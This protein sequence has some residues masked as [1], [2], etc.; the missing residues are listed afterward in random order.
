MLSLS[1]LSVGFVFFVTP[2]AA[3]WLLQLRNLITRTAIKLGT[4]LHEQLSLPAPT[5]PTEQ[6]QP[7]QPQPEPIHVKTELTEPANQPSQEPLPVLMPTKQ[8]PPVSPKAPTAVSARVT[9]ELPP[10]LQRFAKASSNEITEELMVSAL[11]SC[12]SHERFNLFLD[13]FKPESGAIPK[14]DMEAMLRGFIK[15]LEQD[16]SSSSAGKCPGPPQ[17]PLGTIPFGSFA[18]ILRHVL[19]VA[20]AGGPPDGNWRDHLGLEIME[21]LAKQPAAL[22]EVM[23]QAKKHPLLTAHEQELRNLYGDE[24][25]EFHSSSG[26]PIEELVDFIEWLVE[27][28]DPDALTAMPPSTQHLIHEPTPAAPAVV[29]APDVVP[30]T[31]TPKETLT[32]APTAISTTELG[33]SAEATAAAAPEAAETNEDKD[34]AAPEAP[35]P[36]DQDVHKP[37]ATPQALPAEA[38]TAAETETVEEEPAEAA[39]ELS[40]PAQ[41][42]STATSA[43]GQDPQATESA[44]KEAAE[45]NGDK[46][47]AAPEA[48][49]PFDQD[50]HKPKATPQ[51][52]PAEAPTA[53]ETAEAAAELSEPAQAAPTATSAAGQAPQATE[54]AAK[55]EAAAPAMKAS[56][57]A[58]PVP[59]LHL[60]TATPAVAKRSTTQTVLPFEKKARRD[61]DAEQCS[62]AMLAQQA[63]NSKLLA[64][65][66]AGMRTFLPS[67]A[68]AED[69]DCWQAN[70]PQLSAEDHA[71]ALVAELTASGRRCVP[72]WIP[73][74]FEDPAKKAA[75]PTCTGTS[76]VPVPVPAQAAGI[77]ASEANPANPIE[78]KAKAKPKAKGRAQ[79][80]AA[81]ATLP[82][83]KAK[84][85]ASQMAKQK[86]EPLVVCSRVPPLRHIVFFSRRCCC[87]VCINM[88]PFF[89]FAGCIGQS[90]SEGI[91][92]DQGLRDS[93]SESDCCLLTTLQ[94]SSLL[95]GHCYPLAG[96]GCARWQCRSQETPSDLNLSEL[97]PL[98]ERWS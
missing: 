73:P 39:A 44:A 21:T 62:L 52:L 92:K 80:P 42:A 14:K 64:E 88:R 55:E 28:P 40:E 79:A 71:K 11:E 20:T 48:P 41:A 50:V 17:F 26:D 34:P 22:R 25:W 6:V 70:D 3:I 90:Q 32:T 46:D 49:A 67:E 45:T 33:A 37:K 65:T 13:Q 95:H 76:A 56:S 27:H 38:P 12:S 77:T 16:S 10:S 87:C 9:G 93:E 84:T 69:V 36:F 72:G 60:P 63:D 83:P 75:T 89:C 58:R 94:C 24:S 47:P 30:E 97:L 19:D 8:E 53:A 23:L 57:S 15:F 66:L 59:P 74:S 51:A 82:C 78:P 81:P 61:S 18:G 1:C 5:L 85:K 54:S 7:E 29:G 68:G 31:E 96:A 4:M 2:D 91:S 98:P 43:A 86:E 35:A